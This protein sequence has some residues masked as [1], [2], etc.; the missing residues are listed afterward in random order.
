MVFGNT[1]FLIDKV[2]VISL[3]PFAVVSE[4]KVLLQEVSKLLE[5]FTQSILN[6]EY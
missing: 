3:I 2:A 1:E 5:A 4:A 6:S